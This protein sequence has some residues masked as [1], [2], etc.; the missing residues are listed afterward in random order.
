MLQN[1]HYRQGKTT[2]KL[3]LVCQIPICTKCNYSFHN[4]RNLQLPVCMK[5][6][7]LKSIGRPKLSTSTKKSVCI[8]IQNIRKEGFFSKKS[9]TKYK[10]TTNCGFESFKADD[11]KKKGKVKKRIASEVEE[12][13]ISIKKELYLNKSKSRYYLQQSLRSSLML[14]I[15]WKRN[16]LTMQSISNN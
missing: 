11:T 8:P 14:L 3:C 12:N 4:E 7:D 6:V 1:Q 5:H 2:T 16:Q 9:E 15:G 10:D 13:T